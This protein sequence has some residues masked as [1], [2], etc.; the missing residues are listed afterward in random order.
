VSQ[1]QNLK[2]KFEIQNEKKELRKKRKKEKQCCAR[3]GLIPWRRPTS[4]FTAQPNQIG[5]DTLG[6]PSSHTL[7]LPLNS[8]PCHV[9]PTVSRTQRARSLASLP[10]GPALSTLS[11]PRISLAVA[12]PRSQ[13]RREDRAG[14]SHRTGI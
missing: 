9:G 10:C 13:D 11:S 5:A 6:P 7:A 3:L 14:R 4:N 2:S 12:R 1:N 8:A